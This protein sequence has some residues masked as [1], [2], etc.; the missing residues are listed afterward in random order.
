M[1]LRCCDRGGPRAAFGTSQ[2]SSLSPVTLWPGAQYDYTASAGRFVFAAGAC[3]L[4]ADGNVIGPGDFEAQAKQAVE[5]LRRALAD[6][7]AALA[8]VVKAT[9][10]VASSERTDLIQVWNVVS[11]VLGRAP[12]TLLGVTVLGY[13]EQL[14]EIEAIAHLG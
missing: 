11:P 1:R 7:G 12:N 13:P 3:P 4:D 10:Y 6:E 14:V 5:N 8:D 2:A 9:V